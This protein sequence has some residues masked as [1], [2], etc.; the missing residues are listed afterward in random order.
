MI[1]RRDY[2]ITLG[3][4]DLNPS[5]L[6]LRFLVILCRILMTPFWLVSSS[7]DMKGPSRKKASWNSFT[8]I[9]PAVISLVSVYSTIYHRYPSLHSDAPINDSTLLR[10]PRP[11]NRCPGRR[12]DWERVCA[13]ECFIMSF[14]STLQVSSLGAFARSQYTAAMRKRSWVQDGL[15]SDQSCPLPTLTPQL[16][17]NDRSRFVISM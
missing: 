1:A 15:W 14:S 17:P 2:D 12:S 5:V 16:E 6:A 11:A 13:N 10:R 8:N 9:Q 4:S 7:I 3:S